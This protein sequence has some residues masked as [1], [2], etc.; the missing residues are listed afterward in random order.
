MRI[1]LLILII[2][3]FLFTEI[4]T[5]NARPRRPKSCV[6]KVLLPGHSKPVKCSKARKIKNRYF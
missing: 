6:K 1:K 4:P 3:T 2:I 5:A